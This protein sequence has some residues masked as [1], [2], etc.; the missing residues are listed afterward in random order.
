V[1][2]YSLI[3]SGGQTIATKRVIDELKLAMRDLDPLAFLVLKGVSVA[4]FDHG[5]VE[6]RAGSANV[7]ELLN[8]TIGQG[9]GQLYHDRIVTR[10]S[11]GET[12]VLDS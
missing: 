2:R 10:R 6:Y 9:S 3:A 8:Q 1:R 11:V 4:W 7:W 5:L 12:H